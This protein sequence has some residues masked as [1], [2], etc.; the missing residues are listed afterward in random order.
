LQL[1]LFSDEAGR[2]IFYLRFPHT[3][4]GRL[5]TVLPIKA[6]S[7]LLPTKK[8]K[9]GTPPWF[10][11]EGKIALQFLKIYTGCSD[12]KL[13][14]QING[15]WMMQLFCGIHLKPNEEI[16]DKDLIWTTRKFVSEHLD[17]KEF[18][19]VF[20][21]HWKA[22]MKNTHMAM[23]DATCY[24]SYI[25]YP[26][27]VKLLWDGI[28]W[29][30]Q[31]IRYYAK[32]LGLRHRRSKV[33][34]QSIKQL[35]YAKK[36]RKTKKLERRRRRQL[37][38]LINKLLLQFDDLIAY[39]Q[40]QLRL[41]VGDLYLFLPAHFDKFFT[42]CK[43]YEQQRFHYDNPKE[44]IP[45]RIVSLYKPYLRPIIRGKESNGGKRVELTL[46]GRM[47]VNTWQVDGINFI[48]HFSFSA[49]HEGNRLQQGIIFHHQHFGK[50]RQVGADAIYATNKNRKFC[51]RFNIATCFKP[52]GRR[53]LNPD[54]KKQE[55]QAR[56]TIGKIRATVLE[57]SYGNDKNHYD[58]K[59]I[60]ARNEKT[61]ILWVF[62]GMMTANAMK[63]VQRR[64]KKEEKS[65]KQMAR[66]Q[67]KAA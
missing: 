43:I 11:N 14:E 24:E 64:L 47:K 57:G 25:K 27:D 18:Q 23:S 34:E 56:R 32:A 26:T 1:P 31:H 60:K 45:D 63:I 15:N 54:L 16:K 58:L 3:Q 65:K 38:Y 55:D 40:E 6:L 2:S 8:N 17:I 19:S 67:L 41:G 5:R 29:L 37:L 62:F 36:R 46:K 28:E 4:L 30:D 33:K 52:K 49:F 7:K 44:S 22:D 13:L 9:A 20:I 21:E 10:D 42:I 39:W 48:E 35:N 59:K 51:K 12:E 50:L 61:E 66:S 53:T